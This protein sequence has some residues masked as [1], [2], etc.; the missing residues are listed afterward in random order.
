[1]TPLESKNSTTINRVRFFAK[2]ALVEEVAQQKWGLIKLICTQPF[3]HF[4][5]Y[6]LAFIKV[7]TSAN[8][9]KKPDEKPTSQKIQTLG[10]FKLREESP[11]SDQDSSSLF[12]KWKNSKNNSLNESSSLSGIFSVV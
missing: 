1:M 4:A 5:Q 11:D 9:D 10:G 12:A 2:N 3:N 8:T 6:G 7:H